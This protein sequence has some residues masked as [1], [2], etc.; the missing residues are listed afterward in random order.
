M[1]LEITTAEQDGTVTVTVAGEVDMTS[2]PALRRALGQAPAKGRL[3]VDLSAVR[4]LD[5][6]GV[7]VLYDHLDRRPELVVS[8]DAVVLRILD[9]TGLSDLL[10]VHVK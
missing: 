6:A 10:T 3:V 2:A 1:I 9:L 4:F 8:A 7:K 5:S